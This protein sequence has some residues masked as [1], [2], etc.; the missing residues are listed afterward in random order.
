MLKLN[1]VPLEKVNDVKFGTNRD[2]VR[3]DF[4]EYGIPTEFKKNKFS[5]N[6]TDD[7]GAFHVFY[8]EKNEFEA[9]EIFDNVEVLVSGITVFPAN[10]DAVIKIFP[11]MEKEYEYYTSIENSVGLTADDSGKIVSILFGD[12]NYYK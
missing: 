6:T 3:K 7:Y 9:I 1:I 8:N 10:I 11:D 2:E 5:K 12:Y 4:K